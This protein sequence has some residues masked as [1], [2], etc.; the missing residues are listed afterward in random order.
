[1]S[2]PCHLVR[3]QTAAPTAALLAAAPAP[4][5]AHC[6]Q[7]GEIIIPGKK[8][9]MRSLH[10]LSILALA[11]ALWAPGASPCLA[12]DAAADFSATMNP[13]GHWSYGQCYRRAW[14]FYRYAHPVTDASGLSLWVL[15]FEV[16][17]QVSHNGTGSTIVTT[18][19]YPPG[20][21][22]LNPGVEGWNSVVRWTAPAAGTYQIPA[23]FV[24]LSGAGG[25][26]VTTTDVAVLHNNAQLFSG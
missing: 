19:T 18:A 8:P 5:P 9:H 13:S 20:A 14:P 3:P 25:S 26:P 12:D 4:A 16:W 15:G 23:T 7:S 11:V 6:L 1:M 10:Q 21:L 24:G 17:P 22:S 2:R